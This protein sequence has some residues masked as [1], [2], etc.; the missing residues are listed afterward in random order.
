VSAGVERSDALNTSSVINTKEIVM[1]DEVYDMLYREVVKHMEP[2]PDI[3]DCG[4]FEVWLD[5][6]AFESA[7]TDWL[8]GIWKR[9]SGPSKKWIA[10]NYEDAVAEVC[11]GLWSPP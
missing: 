11:S 5:R 10:D 7:V 6:S 3:L 1:R 2:L 9:K 4:P 8:A